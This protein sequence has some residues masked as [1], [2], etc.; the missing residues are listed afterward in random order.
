MN[1]AVM[2]EGIDGTFRLRKLLKRVNINSMEEALV[3]LDTRQKIVVSV[4]I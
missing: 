4:S 3:K 1:A 2:F